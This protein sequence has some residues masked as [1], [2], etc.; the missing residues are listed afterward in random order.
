MNWVGDPLL[1]I[2]GGHFSQK[3]G[4]TA[5][6]YVLILAM[7]TVFIILGLAFIGDDLQVFWSRVNSSYQDVNQPN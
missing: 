7:L 2:F 1:R 5:T 3:R 4:Q 6:E